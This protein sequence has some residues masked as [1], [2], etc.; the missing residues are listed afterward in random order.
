MCPTLHSLLPVFVPL[1]AA[2]FPVTVPLR[3]S[4]RIPEIQPKRSVGAED[5]PDLT[6]DLNELRNV[7]LGSFF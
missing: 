5:A 7:Q 6:E 3:L 4:V 1:T 2:I